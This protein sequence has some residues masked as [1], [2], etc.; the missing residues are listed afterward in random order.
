M[1]QYKTIDI[2]T[3]PS[4]FKKIITSSDRIKI[5]CAWWERYRDGKEAKEEK[6]ER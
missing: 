6:K 1:T 4:D 2:K 5:K 3:T